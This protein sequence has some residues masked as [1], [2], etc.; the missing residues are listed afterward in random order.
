MYSLAVSDLAPPHPRDVRRM[1][2]WLALGLLVFV[3]ALAVHFRPALLARSLPTASAQWIWQPFDARDVLPAIQAAVARHEE[4]LAARRHI[5][6]SQRA[7]DL[8]VRSSSGQVWPLRLI[9]RPDGS[10]DVIVP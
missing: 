2:A 7:I 6:R 10:L 4:L 5:G 9:R 1:R 8:D 3:A